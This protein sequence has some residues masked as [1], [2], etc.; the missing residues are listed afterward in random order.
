MDLKKH[1]IDTIKEWQ[2]K[3]GYREGNMKLYY[4]GESLID[5]L[6]SAE[7][8]QNVVGVKPLTEKQITGKLSE[9]ELQERLTTFCDEMEPLLGR[10]KISGSYERYC[11]DI[12]AKGC[13]Y[14]AGKV[15]DPEFLKLFLNTITT[16]GNA[17]EQ[18]R[19]CFGAYAAEHGLT[20]V[21]EEIEE[22]HTHAGHAFYFTDD[23]IE[24]YIYWV[25]EN[26]F[27]L[28]YHRFTKADY[29]KLK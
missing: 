8:M 21:E 17:M 20:Y 13:A 24:E 1:I 25:E 7:T 4:P 26:E 15:P 9:G 16:P 14:V 22:E 27:G 18:V 5:L 23:T 6:E 28:T 10:I 19:D 12:P 11:L 29:E 3:I 2:L